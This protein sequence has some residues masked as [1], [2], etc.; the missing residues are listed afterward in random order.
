MVGGVWSNPR[1]ITRPGALL[2]APRD[3][4]MANEGCPTRRTLV[5]E[6]GRTGNKLGWDISDD[7]CSAI[8]A[9]LMSP[10]RWGTPKHQLR[11]ATSHYKGLGPQE[12]YQKRRRPP[13]A[14]VPCRRARNEPTPRCRNMVLATKALAALTPT[15]NENDISREVA[16]KAIPRPS[17]R[18]HAPCHQS[19]PFAPCERSQG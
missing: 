10:V 11:R 8:V 6:P 5:S 12:T 3:R 1:G 15:N 2:Y 14:N 9:A 7:R 4:P 16:A 17:N 19:Q 18:P 13:M